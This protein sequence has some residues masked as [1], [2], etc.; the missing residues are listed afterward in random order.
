MQW[1]RPSA[2]VCG[3]RSAPAGPLNFVFDLRFDNPTCR[4]MKDKPM[5]REWCYRKNGTTHGPVTKAELMTKRER[6][7]VA[8]KGIS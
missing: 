7:E 4:K 3:F 8:Q 6:Y 2:L 5:K 1:T